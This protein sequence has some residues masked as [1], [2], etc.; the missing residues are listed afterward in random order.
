[1][2][3]KNDLSKGKEVK[4]QKGDSKDEADFGMEEA[5]QKMCEATGCSVSIEKPF[6]LNVQ[7]F[8]R[9]ESSLGKNCQTCS[10]W[11]ISLSQ[12]QIR[13]CFT[14]DPTLTCR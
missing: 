6:V 3:C 8:L 1:M 11:I 9:H 4:A 5:I 14:L 2:L 13:L 7:P 12:P 10:L